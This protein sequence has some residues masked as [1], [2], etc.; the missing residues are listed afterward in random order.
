MPVGYELV[1]NQFLPLVVLYSGAA[2]FPP[3][4]ASKSTLIVEGVVLGGAEWRGK[5]EKEI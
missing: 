3:K 1:I 5:P 4:T 2:D